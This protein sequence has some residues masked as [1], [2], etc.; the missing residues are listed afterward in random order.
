[1]KTT[2]E[3]GKR[4]TALQK[5]ARGYRAKYLRQGLVPVSV[6]IS[7]DLLLRARLAIYRRGLPGKKTFP[8]IRATLS[9]A[10]SLLAA[11]PE[12]PE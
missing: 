3:A 9:K 10:L 7:G 11:P 1:M 5:R 6:W 2:K 8:Q 4:R 12:R